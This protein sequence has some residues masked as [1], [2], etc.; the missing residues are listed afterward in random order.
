MKQGKFVT[1]EGPDGSGK[2]SVLNKLLQMIIDRHGIDPIVTREPGG[3]M[4]GEKI[5]EI[6]LDV[7][8][9]QMDPRTEALLYAAS[10]RQHVVET[11]RPAVEAGKLVISDRYVDS[12]IAYQ[13]TGRDIPVKL[14]KE[15]NDFAIE[16]YL[17]DVTFL[18]DVPAEV[19]LQRI[20]QAQGSRQY[21]RLDQESLVFHEQTREAFLRLAKDQ[22]QRIHVIDGTKPVEEVAQVCY[23]LLII[24]GI[25]EEEA[26]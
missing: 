1:L 3:N 7:D 5:R 24:H 6:I 17:P 21:D 2:T 12:S 9:T 26:T 22:S 19:G 4:I 16:G 14:V 20:K 25:L 13:G 15:I 11:I 23:Q 10:R 18:I 8:H